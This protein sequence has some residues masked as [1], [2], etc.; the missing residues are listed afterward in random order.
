MPLITSYVFCGDRSSVCSSN[1]GP[2]GTSA[3]RCKG[4]LWLHGRSLSN[5]ICWFPRLRCRSSSYVYAASSPRPPS[6]PVSNGRVKGRQKQPQ[7][8]V[9]APSPAPRAAPSLPRGPRQPGRAGTVGLCSPGN[10]PHEAEPTRKEKKPQCLNLQAS[11]RPLHF[12]LASLPGG[13]L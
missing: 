12:P 4:A 7:T 9:V 3:F 11:P 13:T 10:T 1:G 6:K 2:Q 5:S 8:L